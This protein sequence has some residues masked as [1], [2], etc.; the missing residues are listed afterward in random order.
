LFHESAVPHPFRVLV[1]AARVGTTNLI[2]SSS[3]ATRLKY[4]EC[5]CETHFTGICDL[6]RHP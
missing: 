3:M 6:C 1:F 2:P 5:I 4:A